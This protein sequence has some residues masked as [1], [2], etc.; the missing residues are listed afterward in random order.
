MKRHKNPSNTS[1]T[2]TKRERKR[3]RER[4]RLWTHKTTAE[5]PILTS[6]PGAVTSTGGC[7]MYS[8][9][10]THL[11]TFKRLRTPNADTKCR[12]LQTAAGGALLSETGEAEA[13]G[14]ALEWGVHQ[15]GL[16]V[17]RNMDF[18]DLSRSVIIRAERLS[19]ITWREV[20]SHP[21]GTQLE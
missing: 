15:R 11:D 16:D 17:T 13:S 10:F 21:A 14:L 2:P 9:I 7:Y 19:H 3:E 1:F 18:L 4:G 20:T 12:L 5:I 8:W 6:F